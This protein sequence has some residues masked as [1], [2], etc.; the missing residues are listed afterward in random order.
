MYFSLCL[1]GKNRYA[2]FIRFLTFPAMIKPQH[3]LVLL[4]VGLAVTA[5]AELPP[6]DPELAED[7]K[8]YI[9]SLDPTKPEDCIGFINRHLSDILS[10]RFT[11]ASP[12][13]AEL[14]RMKSRHSTACL[15]NRTLE[16][17]SKEEIRSMEAA[18]R[19]A[20]WWERSGWAT[21]AKQSLLRI[22]PD[23]ADVARQDIRPTA[24]TVP[25]SR[26]EDNAALASDI[27]AHSAQTPSAVK[28]SPQALAPSASASSSKGGWFDLAS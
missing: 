8:A 25:N 2:L 18:E 26:T 7:L 10:T 23:A 20:P 27:T 28:S 13:E 9:A 6:D 15:R 19:A 17:I 22:A 16:G 11:L 12:L 4:G 3:L 24:D 21:R 14:A 5:R 1:S